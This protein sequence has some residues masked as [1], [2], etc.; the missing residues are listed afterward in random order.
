[1][2][3]RESPLHFRLAASY[4]HILSA[5]AH[6]P[7]KLTPLAQNT[8]GEGPRHLPFPTWNSSSLQIPPL[9]RQATARFPETSHALSKIRSNTLLHRVHRYLAARPR[10]RRRD[11]HPSRHSHR[12]HLQRASQGPA[13]LHQ[14]RSHRKDLRRLNSNSH[15]RER[16]GPLERHRLTG[17]DRFP[18][19]YLSVGRGPSERRL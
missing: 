16:G 4:N 18:H 6:N 14:R 13:H 11:H 8:R 3:R 19:A 15:R 10:T 2:L 1:M 7:S 12:R 5:L 17:H 9:L